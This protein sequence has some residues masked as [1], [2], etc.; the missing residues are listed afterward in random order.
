MSKK[1]SALLVAIAFLLS[2]VTAISVALAIYA[3]IDDKRLALLFASAAVL[4]DI[5]K[6][7]AWPVAIRV[8]RGSTA[9]LTIACAFM[10]SIVS[11]WATYDRLMSS[12]TISKATHDVM[13]TDRVQS[14]TSLAQKD[15]LLI[16][17]LDKEISHATVQANELRARG[18]V[19]KALEL[20]ESVAARAASQRTSAIARINDGSLEIA[21]IKSS[22]AK[23]SSLPA[24]LAH[25]LC[26]GF[27]MSLEV[28]PAL[29]LSGVRSSRRSF[30][31]VADSNSS[32][33]PP[34]G[35]SKAE[36]P[37]T[38]ETLLDTNAEILKTL[39]NQAKTTTPG[40]PIKLKDFAKNSRIGNLRAC[41]I[42]RNAEA[43]GV[44]KKTTIGYVAT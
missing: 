18:M 44:I 31:P 21:H 43:L 16:S 7:L 41:E 27:A 6:Y 35:I 39:V 32:A 4:L 40:T 2:S 14:L 37:K 28:V 19:S 11:G 8:L 1:L 15:S 30:L 20:E 13:T 22:V 29:I 3:L 12:I 17:Q 42:F 36:T 26:L 10:L 38:P 34:S 5:F 24:L 25:F 23:A 9:A 33:S